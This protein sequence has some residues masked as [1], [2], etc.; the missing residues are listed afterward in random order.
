MAL[1][2]VT[3]AHRP[4]HNYVQHA[5]ELPPMRAINA[6]TRHGITPMVIGCNVVGP[7][8]TS[9]FQCLMMNWLGGIEIAKTGDVSLLAEL[10]R[11]AKP[12]KVFPGPTVLSPGTWPHNWE[13]LRMN[14]R[15]LMAIVA[16]VAGTV[17]TTILL[18]GPGRTVAADDKPAG[19]IYAHC[20]VRF[21]RNRR[22]PL[23]W[24]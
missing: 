11:A 17:V 7:G 19:A 6:A 16:V 5:G 15:M 14:V 24:S 21:R 9:C 23:L 18:T 2:D 4:V 22:M 1:I 13:G 3:P 8:I 20:P 10:R 12:E